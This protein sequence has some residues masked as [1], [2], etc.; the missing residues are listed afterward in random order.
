LDALENQ[1]LT[2]DSVLCTI[3][4]ACHEGGSKDLTEDKESIKIEIHCPV[5][6][7]IRGA[8]RDVPPSIL[9]RGVQIYMQHGTP[10]IQRRQRNDPAFFEDLDIAREEMEKW[11]ATCTLDFAPEIPIELASDNR[12]KDV[13]LPLLSVADSL[14]HGAEA[15]AAL[16]ELN[17]SRPPRDDGEQ[18]LKDVK[19]VFEALGVDRAFKK[20]LAKELVQR[21]D[22]MWGCYRGLDGRQSPHELRPT[23]LASLLGR[24]QTYAKTVWPDGPRKPK[25]SAAGYYKSQ[26]EKAWAEHCPGPSTRSQ[27]RKIIPLPRP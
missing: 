27:D 23:E 26:F 12:L 2:A 10:R 20:D 21:G 15:R 3:L 17:A 22:P 9:S 19:L 25:S 8:I 5:I 18:A 11:A 14:G 4:D 6:W 24:F 1:K 7:A 13:C 16:I